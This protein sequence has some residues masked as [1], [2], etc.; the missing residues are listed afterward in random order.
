MNSDGHQRDLA[1]VDVTV[2][3]V[4][5]APVEGDEE[6]AVVRVDRPVRDELPQDLLEQRDVVRDVVAGDVEDI[7]EEVQL[8]YERVVGR[9][10]D[11]HV[12]DDFVEGA[13]RDDEALEAAEDG[14]VVEEVHAGHASSDTPDR[15]AV[16][17]S[18]GVLG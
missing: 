10:E 11:C 12:A 2:R 6:P 18:G 14:E 9:S 16:Q 3:V 7:G 13:A 8:R 4:P 17:P 1:A 5:Q 15:V